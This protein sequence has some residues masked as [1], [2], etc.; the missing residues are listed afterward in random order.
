LPHSLSWGCA[1][2]DPCHSYLFNRIKVPEEPDLMPFFNTTFAN[3]K[4][5]VHVWCIFCHF[6]WH[7]FR[8]PVS[9]KKYHIKIFKKVSRYKIRF[10]SI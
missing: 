3:L 6:I 9:R 5:G 1:A 8:D 7:I 2:G 4:Y 10:N